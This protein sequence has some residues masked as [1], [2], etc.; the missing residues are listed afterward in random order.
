[1]N[2]TNGRICNIMVTNTKLLPNGYDGFVLNGQNNV[3]ER[4]TA[5]YCKDEGVSVMTGYGH[6]VAF[7]RIENCGSITDEGNGRGISVWYGSQAIVAGN[8][9]GD[10]LRGAMCQGADNDTFADFRNNLITLNDQTF[11]FNVQGAGGYANLIDNTITNNADD[12]IR[13]MNG[14]TFYRRGNILINDNEAFYGTSPEHPTWVNPVEVF[15]LITKTNTPY[16]SWLENITTPTDKMQV[17][18]G[19]GKCQCV[20]NR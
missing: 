19:S 16:P 2:G 9:V 8:Y 13:Y 7:C 6:A 20:L 17:G 3:L 10:N 12:G 5:T 18:M 14:I 15:S 4:C 11:G 1:M